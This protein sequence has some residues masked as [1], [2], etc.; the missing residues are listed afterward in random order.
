MINF[1]L[2]NEYVCSTSINTSSHTLLKRKEL[3]SLKMADYFKDD[4]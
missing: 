4:N 2:V 3:K 1:G